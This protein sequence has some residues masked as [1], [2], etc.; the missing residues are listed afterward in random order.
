MVIKT[1][2]IRIDLRQKDFVQSMGRKPKNQQE[3]NAWSARFEKYLL[4]GF[5]YWDLLYR[6]ARDF[7]KP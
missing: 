5:I 4:N 2:S 1:Y 6:C 3:F 7:M